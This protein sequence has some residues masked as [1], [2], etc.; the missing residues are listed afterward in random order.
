MSRMTAPVGEVTMPMSAAKRVW[1]L[2]RG[3]K[4]AFGGELAATLLEQ[5][6]QSACTR[7]LEILDDDLIGRLARDRR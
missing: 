7:G 6:H 4:Q 2:A 3:I 1:L 5:R